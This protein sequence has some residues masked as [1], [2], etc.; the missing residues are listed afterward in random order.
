M[1]GSLPP[2][3]VL[4][5]IVIHSYH[6]WMDPEGEFKFR[7]NP[8]L[9]TNRSPTRRV[10]IVYVRYAPN[11][12]ETSDIIEFFSPFGGVSKSSEGKYM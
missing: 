3:G 5:F 4:R 6:M 1:A 7:I 12:S 10:N 8:H 2:V 9:I 11:I